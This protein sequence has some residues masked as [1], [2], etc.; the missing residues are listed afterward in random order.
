[1]Q[2]LLDIL[3]ALADPTRLKIMLLI[4]DLELAMGE[5]AEVLDQSQPRV[6]RHVRIL[7]EAGLVRRNK[8]GAWVF[9][10]LGQHVPTLEIY[11]LVDRL[12]G[13]RD[14]IAAERARLAQVRAGRQKSVDSWFDAHA[15]EWDFMRGLEGPETAIEAAILDAARAGTVGRLLDIGTGTGRIIEL[16]GKHATSA[17]GVDRSPEMLRIARAKLAEADAHATEVR[18]ADM[19]ALPFEAHSFDTVTLH[20]VLHFADD[21]ASVVAE[22]ARMVAPGGRLLV[23]DYAPHAREDFRSRFQHVRLGFEDEAVVGWMAG[24]GL[25][26]MRLAQHEGPELTV[27]LWQGKSP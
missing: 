6:S 15:A 13:G 12:L 23:V 4:R 7:A 20:H 17:I 19:R 3:A 26:G 14:I 1:M 18:H 22:A 9:V 25:K 10:G 21:P 11:A 27:T 2:R 5:L 16:L 8:E 24:A